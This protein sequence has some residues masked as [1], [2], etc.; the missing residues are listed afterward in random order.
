[1]NPPRTAV[2]FVLAACFGAG[3]A[4]LDKTE[5]LVRESSGNQKPG[6]L[7]DDSVELQMLCTDIGLQRACEAVPTNTLESKEYSMFVDVKPVWDSDRGRRS[8]RGIS[9][10]SRTTQNRS[11]ADLTKSGE[12]QSGEQC[13]PPGRLIF[14]H[15]M[16]TG[17]LSLEKFLKCSCSERPNGLCTIRI[18]ANH[19]GNTA[20]PKGYGSECPPSICSTHSP[21]TET[22]EA[23]GPEFAN[24]KRFTTIREPV[25]RVWSFYNYLRRWYK[26]YI[27]YTLKEILQNYSHV[28]L[29]EGLPE[30]DQCLHC[31]QQLSNAMAAHHYAGVGTA[32]QV[33]ASMG[34]IIDLGR[35]SDFPRISTKFALFPE[36][37]SLSGSTECTMA[38][39]EATFY[40]LGRHPDHETAVLIA[41]H[42]VEDLKLYEYV[43]TLPQYES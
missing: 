32:K 19:W 10:T 11:R 43:R 39:K 5:V 34:A 9:Q 41:Q 29:N 22:D 38:H 35:L 6:P 27:Q 31:H 18:A 8:F 25:S 4:L 7:P 30:T 13:L 20:Q 23:C 21:P 24:A 40:P 28:D 3:S 14:Q 15:V 2:L 16:K 12:L 33:L 17:G 1:M 36:H 42:N 37:L 26:P